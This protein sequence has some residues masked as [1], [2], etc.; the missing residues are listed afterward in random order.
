MSQGLGTVQRRLLVALYCAE[1]FNGRWMELAEEPALESDDDS[2]PWFAVSQFHLV[3]TDHAER[4]E[5]ATKRL[6]VRRDREFKRSRRVPYR[7]ALRTLEQ[8]GL[9]EAKLVSVDLNLLG[10]YAP[11]WRGRPPA[12]REVWVA[13]LTDRGKDWVRENAP[14][15]VQSMGAEMVRTAERF[16]PAERWQ[17]AEA[18]RLA[19]Y[20]QGRGRRPATITVPEVATSARTRALNKS[21]VIELLHGEGFGTEQVSAVLRQWHR[22]EQR[23]QRSRFREPGPALDDCI[24]GVAEIEDLRQLLVEPR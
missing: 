23:Q 12:A 21:D 7:R 20:R 19:R 1:N 10:Q 3:E 14:E 2:G 18:Q 22:E 16:D 5:Y 8:R 9:A 6:T 15:Q 17:I 4:F 11:P 24:F 13:R